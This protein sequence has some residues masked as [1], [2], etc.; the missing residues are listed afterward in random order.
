MHYFFVSVQCEQRTELDRRKGAPKRRPGLHGVQEVVPPDGARVPLPQQRDDVQGVR[1]HAALP[2]GRGANGV[3]GAIAL[4]PG[5]RTMDSLCGLPVGTFL[6]A[7]AH[8][9]RWPDSD[10]PG[11][12]VGMQFHTQFQS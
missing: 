6:R 3:G 10:Y 7:K 4:V 5:F 11:L 8:T 12:G 1:R 9:L 2:L